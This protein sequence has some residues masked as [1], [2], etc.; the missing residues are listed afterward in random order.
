M[1]DCEGG[2]SQM[3]FS[4]NGILG[5]LKILREDAMSYQIVIKTFSCCLLRWVQITLHYLCAVSFSVIVINEN[6][7]TVYV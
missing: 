4:A 3:M 2:F 6:E 1:Q 7:E 5:V